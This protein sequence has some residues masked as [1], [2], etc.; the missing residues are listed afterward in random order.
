MD[1]LHRQAYLDAM[2]VDVYFPRVLLPAAPASILCEMPIPLATREQ[3]SGGSQ[4]ATASPQIESAGQTVAGSQGRTAAMQALLN[5][6]TGSTP[7]PS[8]ALPSKVE[9]TKLPGPPATPRFILSV[10]RVGDIIIVDNAA[11][12]GALEFQRLQQNFFSALGLSE[13]MTASNFKWPIVES[14]HLDQS[15]LAA[16]QTLR[17]FVQHQ[18]KSTPSK[19][20]LLMGDTACT[21]LLDDVPV[22]GE[23]LETFVA[24][25][26]VLCA[27]S[28]SSSIGDGASKSKIWQAVKPL[29]KI[30][31]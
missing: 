24:D 23:W 1:E 2:G 7:K 18:V 16:K 6:M 29:R 20:L 4:N 8:R 21:Y 30:L 27:P 14:S 11:A 3:V 22:I 5:E 25:L 28:L 15:E 19:A 13:G 9:G 12:E 10:T 17:A 26:P 31:A